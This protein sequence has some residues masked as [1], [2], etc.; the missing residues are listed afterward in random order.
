MLND[1]AMVGIVVLGSDP[2]MRKLPFLKIL[3]HQF[4]IFQEK[5]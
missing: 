3:C 4:W 5:H 2:Y 1:W